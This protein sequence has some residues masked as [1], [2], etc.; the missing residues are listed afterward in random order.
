MVQKSEIDMFLRA[1]FEGIASL[2]PPEGF[3]REL[4][5]PTQ[6]FVG[7][8]EEIAYAWVILLVL[9][10]AVVTNLPSK[11]ARVLHRRD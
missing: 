1:E 6:V 10:I 2:P 7:M 9:A 5:L 4:V 11:S 8:F 3:V